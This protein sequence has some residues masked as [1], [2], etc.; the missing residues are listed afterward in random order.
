MTF[1]PRDRRA[2]P[3]Q[4]RTPAQEAATERAFRIF[5]LRGL[6]AQVSLLTGERRAA[7][8]RLVD[9]ELTALGATPQAAHDAERWA[10]WDAEQL[11]A[12]P[13]FAEVDDNLPF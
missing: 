12:N 3:R 5:R 7:A 6:Y 8:E 13:S 11:P 4:P 10:K 2:K 1:K 9:E